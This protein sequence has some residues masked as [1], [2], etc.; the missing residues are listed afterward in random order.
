MPFHGKGNVILFVFIVTM[1]ILG[2]PKDSYKNLWRESLNS[3]LQQFDQYQ[4]NK[5]SPFILTNSTSKKIT[6]YD[7]GNPNT[8]LGQAQKCGCVKSVN[9]IP[10]IVQG[11]D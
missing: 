3:D 2:S 4:Q 7:V 5:Q 9:G 1:V 10:N 6:T 11:L 8:G